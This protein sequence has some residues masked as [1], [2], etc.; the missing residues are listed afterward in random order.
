MYRYTVLPASSGMNGQNAALFWTCTCT[1]WHADTQTCAFTFTRDKY[2]S[3]CHSS[4]LSTLSLLTS[5]PSYPIP[6]SIPI[7]FL[8]L[9]SHPSL[10]LSLLLPS[11]PLTLY[12]PPSSLSNFI[13]HLLHP[14]SLYFSFCLSLIIPPSPNPSASAPQSSPC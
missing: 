1:T 6:P 2:S 8:P 7:S 13:T 9:P 14:F 3:A 4:L 5:P 12:L 11:L 10:P